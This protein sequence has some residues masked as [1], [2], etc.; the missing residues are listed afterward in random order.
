MSSWLC[1]IPAVSHHS[2]IVFSVQH[3]DAATTLVEIG[4][5][6]FLAQLRPHLDD[7]LHLL[8][9]TTVENMMRLPTTSTPLRGTMTLTSR[10]FPPVPDD[11]LTATSAATI[12][13]NDLLSKV[14]R[15]ALYLQKAPDNSRDHIPIASQGVLGGNMLEN[16]L[17]PNGTLQSS[18]YGSSQQ[19][20]SLSMESSYNFGES[21]KLNVA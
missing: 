7:T 2:L 1:L 19:T 11:N 16:Q 15:P 3:E 14:A 4:A 13:S 6:D 21:G 9:G 17:C 5:V 18:T 10:Q 20:S 12:G 8:L